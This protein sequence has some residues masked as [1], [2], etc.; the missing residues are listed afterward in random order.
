[1]TAKRK[2][3]F[4]LNTDNL[5][6][7]FHELWKE[8]KFGKYQDLYDLWYHIA[9][10]PT[11]AIKPQ[12]DRLLDELNGFW[13]EICRSLSAGDWTVFSFVIKDAA[14]AKTSFNRWNAGKGI[15]KEAAATL[16]I[17][18]TLTAF[19]GKTLFARNYP[20]FAEKNM[21]TDRLRDIICTAM[22]ITDMELRAR[23]QAEEAFFFPAAAAHMLALADEK[24]AEAIR[25][26]LHNTLR[27]RAGRSQ[28]KDS[29]SFLNSYCAALWEECKDIDLRD[30]SGDNF[31]STTKNHEVADL[32]VVPSFK[33]SSDRHLGAP[34]AGA[35]PFRR[36]LIAGSG[37][38]K[39]S[40]LQAVTATLLYPHLKQAG[41]PDLRSETAEAYARL[42]RRLELEKDYFPLLIKAADFNNAPETEKLEELALGSWCSGYKEAIGLHLD[43]AHTE[44]R[45]LL[46]LDA[47]DELESDC[48]KDFG[49]LVDEFL[50]LYPDCR[51]LVTSRPIDF[52]S[53]RS[54]RFLREIEKWELTFRQAQELIT[55]WINNDITEDTAAAVSR[56]VDLFE[57]NPYFSELAKN[58]YLLSCALFYRSGRSHVTPHGT[59]SALVDKL[60]E[61]RWNLA[62]Y[63]KD[64][65]DAALMRRILAYTACEMM[66]DG[67]TALP[68]KDLA[69]TFDRAAEA[70]DE[71]ID[72]R[73]WRSMAGDM[74]A[75]AG[76]LTLEKKGYVFQLPL[77]AQF[78]AAEGF[79]ETNADPEDLL[80]EVLTQDMAQ[81][82]LMLFSL[83]KQKGPRDKMTP[84]L[85]RAL[86][87]RSALSTQA[88]EHLLLGEI[89]E[90]LLL[91][92]FG[93]NRVVNTEDAKAPLLRYFA[94]MPLLAERFCALAAEESLQPVLKELRA[95]NLLKEDDR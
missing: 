27:A 55:R 71:D 74:A 86:L 43:S 95:N 20:R 58:P 23:I 17:L 88:Q 94:A 21:P 41:C 1:M 46:M 13:D 6:H 85:Y 38:G 49:A 67:L 76:L 9:A 30:S 11:E 53:F 75:S 3:A 8:E 5:I 87:L 69:E 50:L 84:A 25:F 73:V 26:W 7:A 44:G 35:D 12:R 79:M 45:L 47:L 78:L 18:M 63:E 91:N 56:I 77:L 32:Y 22:G 66:K 81:V 19:H 93:E 52:R 54:F 39:T 61:K 51:L 2:G 80:P 29:S 16:A 4:I 64:G 72:P 36:I 62:D 15:D 68:A 82:L 59:L 24:K 14:G 92:T 37:S 57:K 48:R 90:G 10:E 28:Q 65:I 34:T 33:C 42:K 70:L 40:L 89:F 60:I 83:G 31:S